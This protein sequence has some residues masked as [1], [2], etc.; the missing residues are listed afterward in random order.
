MKAQNNEHKNNEYD[1]AIIGAGC[2]GLAAAMYSGR[3]ELKTVVFGE[4]VGGTIIT[5]D[6]VEN[7]PGF[8]RLTGYELAEKLKEHALSYP[9]VTIIEEKV[10]NVARENEN[11]GFVLEASSG[12]Y[13]AKTIIFSTGTEW[14][15]LN[16][17]GE[18]EFANRGVHYCALCDGTFYKDKFVAVIGGSD[19]AAKEALLLTQ[20]AKRV[21][22]IYRGEKIRPEPIN[23]NRVMDNKKIEIIYRTNLKEIK[24][25]KNVKSVVLDNPYNGSTEFA[26]DAIFVAIGHNVLSE[27]AKNLGVK[28]NAKNEIIIDRESKTNISGVFAAGDCVDTVFKQAITGVGEAV[29]ASYSAYEHIKKE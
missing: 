9:A 26:L 15:K 22:M 28:L 16:I 5:T 23:Y 13:H 27:L 1:I 17:K 12:K 8:V 14:K 19:S 11:N 18:K 10:T 2:A 24:G 25:E 6:N 7:Y 20:F 21:F 29:S 4:I 3:F